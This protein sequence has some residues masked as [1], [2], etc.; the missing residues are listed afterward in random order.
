[1]TVRE[2]GQS[3]V[4]FA[5]VLPLVAVLALAIAQV[6]L[7]SRERVLVTHAARVGARA[8]SVGAGD[9]DVRRDVLAA[10]D[11]DPTRVAVDVSRSADQ[12]EV[13]VRYRSVTDLPLVGALLDDVELLGRAR[14]PREPP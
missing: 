6:A 3:T 11:L 5:L 4:E 10:V 2:R 12:V 7:V 14:M 13:V 1:M 9:G 8:A